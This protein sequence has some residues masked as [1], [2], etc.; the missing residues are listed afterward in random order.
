MKKLL[1]V[2]ALAFCAGMYAQETVVKKDKDTEFKSEVISIDKD[3]KMMELLD[4]AS[5]KT[6]KIKI[7]NADKIVFNMATNEIVVTGKYKYSFDGEVT[8]GAMGK[9]E[10][11]YK[12]GESTVYVN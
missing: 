12:L 5:F 4:N 7:E 10:L 3:T 9:K 2:A 6:E 1:L 11:R 8:V